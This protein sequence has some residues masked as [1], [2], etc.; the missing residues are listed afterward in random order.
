MSTVIQT[1]EQPGTRPERRPTGR[2]VLMCRPEHFTVVLPDQPVDGPGRPPTDTEPRRARSGRRCTTPTSTSASTCTS[3]TRSTAC[4]TWS[5]RPT[6]ASCIDGIAYGAKFTYPERQPEGPAYM[7]WFRANGFDVREPEDDQRGRG[8]LPARRRHDPRRH[9]LP[10][11]RRA[12]TTSSR[13][14]LRPRGRHAA[15]G[16]PELLP[17]RHRDRGARPDAG[18]G[19]HRLPAERVRRGSPRRS[20]DERYP[21]AII[22]T[23]E[24]A[25]VLGLNSLQRRLQR[26]HRLARHRLRAPAAR[27]RLQPDRRR[28]LRAAARR[29]RR[30]VLH[31]GAARDDRRRRPTRRRPSAHRRSRRSTPPTTTTRCPSSSRSATAP[32]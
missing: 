31:A 13:A 10:Q 15:A 20:C 17:P 2:T 25:A 8:R 5:T 12:A 32:G 1:D 3:S 26:R 24:D 22:V 28:P 9:R 11:R 7:D 4:P 14:H 19:A 30:E 6:A 16:R 27:A 29:R 18:P 21:D 23:D